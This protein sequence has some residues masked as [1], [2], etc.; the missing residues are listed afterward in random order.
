MGHSGKG[1]SYTST[2]QDCP[3][4]FFWRE[5]RG[6]VPPQSSMSTALLRGELSHQLIALLLGGVKPQKAIETVA[7]ELLGV[8]QGYEDQLELLAKLTNL[9]KWYLKEFKHPL[10]SIRE[11]EKRY[12]FLNFSTRLDLVLEVD[13]LVYI[14]DHKTTESSNHSYFFKK[15]KTGG[16]FLGC[17]AVY[18]NTHLVDKARGVIVEVVDMKKETII[19]DIAAFSDLEQREFLSSMVETQR[20]I[21]E[22]IS[23]DLVP[24]NWEKRLNQCV[25]GW[26]NCLYIPLCKSGEHPYILDHMFLNNSGGVDNG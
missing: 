18:N 3:R 15:A 6:Y 25:I 1:W 16:Q 23:K 20:Q 7:A 13:G 21:N 24:E 22:L 10:D 12:E 9:S 4:R 11:I 2:F 8:Q 26:E 19:E 14:L 17:L 5:I